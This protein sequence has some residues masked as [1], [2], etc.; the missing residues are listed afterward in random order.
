MREVTVPVSKFKA[1]CLKL[2]DDVGQRKVAIVVTKRG[3]PIARVE[4]IKPRRRK[5]L[6]GSLKG[7]VTILGDITAPI[8]EEWDAMT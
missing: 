5:P 6:F 2:M 4:A 8:D 7:S 1:H 3:K